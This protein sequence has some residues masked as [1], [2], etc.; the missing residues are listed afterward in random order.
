LLA[1]PG[2]AIASPV[3]QLA[4]AHTHGTPYAEVQQ[5]DQQSASPQQP[6]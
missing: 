6:Q 2:Q 5:P 3:E 4:A 1:L